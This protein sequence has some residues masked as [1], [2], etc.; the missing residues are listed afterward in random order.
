MSDPILEAESLVA[1]VGTHCTEPIDLSL[2]L[3]HMVALIGPSGVGKTTLLRTLAGL[4]DPIS[5]SIRHVGARPVLCFQEAGLLP[6]RDALGNVLFGLGRRPSPG[7][8]VY[9]LELLDRLGLDGLA[10]RATTELSGGQR[11]RVALAR[12]MIAAETAVLVDEPFVHLD[13]DAAGLVIAA[14][15]ALVESGTAVGVALHART[16]A[17][18]LAAVTVPVRGGAL[19]PP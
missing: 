13:D 11:R 9:A 19:P 4:R 8:H 15:H 7:D 3:E 14:L 16:D 17:D 12:A 6:W 5:G 10:H 1:G 18:R 2:G